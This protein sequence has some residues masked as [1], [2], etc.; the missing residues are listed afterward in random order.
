MPEQRDRRGKRAMKRWFFV[1]LLLCASSVATACPLCLGAFRSSVAQQLVNLPHAVLAQPSA[2]GHD[3]RVVAVIKGERPEDG[4]IPAEEIQLDDVVAASAT[5][6]LVRDE[7]WSMWVGLGAVAVEHAGWLSQVATGKRPSDMN[8][9]EWRAHVALMLPHLED[10]EPLVAKIA[11]GELAA[12]PYAALMQ[13]RASDWGPKPRQFACAKKRISRVESMPIRLFCLEAKKS[14]Y[15]KR[16]LRYSES[17]RLTRGA[18]RIVT[19]VGRGMR[20]T[21]SIARRAV[22]CGRPS[23][24]VLAP[25]AGAKPVDDDRQVTVTMRSRTPG[26]ARSSR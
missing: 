6:L 13:S 7:G 24:V 17:S 10:R 5:L 4:I 2:D 26:R 15:E 20:W 8:S 14:L 21:Q 3:Y 1:A 25:W 9:D 16:K 18:L 23:R 11:Y 12:A 19:N 22:R